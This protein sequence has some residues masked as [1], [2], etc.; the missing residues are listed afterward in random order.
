MSEVLVLIFGSRYGFSIK[1]KRMEPVLY[2]LNNKPEM[3][4]RRGAAAANLA[5]D[6]RE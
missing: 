1:L 5:T 6:E 4:L 3:P 2:S